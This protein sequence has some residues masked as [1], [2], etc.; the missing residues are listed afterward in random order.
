VTEMF[1]TIDE[2][3]EAAGRKGSH[4]FS[5]EVLDFFNGKV[6]PRVYGG[7]VFVTSEQGPTDH[8][9]RLWTLRLALDNGDIL[10]VGKFQAFESHGAAVAAAKRIGGFI[11]E[12]QVEIWTDEK[13]PDPDCYDYAVYVDGE[14]VGYSDTET[15]CEALVEEIC[16]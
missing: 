8:F 5:D 10:T 9:P 14:K 16:S 3:K 15:I 12:G 7:R 11:E 2:I 6:Y 1:Q 4:W 13:D